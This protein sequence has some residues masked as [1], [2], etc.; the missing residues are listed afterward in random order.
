[1]RT[2]DPSS[3]LSICLWLLRYARRRWTGLVCVVALTLLLAG[4]KALNPWP[5]KFIVDQVLMSQPMPPWAGNALAWL[6]YAESPTQRLAWAVGATLALFLSGWALGL[7]SSIAHISFGQRMVY[8]LAADLFDHLQRLSLRYHGRK[9]VGDSIRRVTSDS[10]CVSTIIR[11]A[12]LPVGSSLI[13]LAVMVII[14]WKLDPGL[15]LAAVAVMPMLI[16]TLRLYAKPMMDRSYEQ[17]Q[18]EGQIYDRIEETFGAIPVVQAFAR[19]QYHD[20]QFRA[21][22]DAALAAA[23]RSTGVQLQFKILTGLATALGTAGI[24]W[25]GAA[26]VLDGR[27]SVGSILVFLAYLG[28]LYGPLEAIMYSSM[29]IQGAIGGARRV[30]EVFQTE[31]EVA[32]RPGARSMPVSRGHV[33]IEHVVFG[34]D[35]D[36]PVLRDV[37][38]EARPGQMIAIVGAS[39]AGK[40]TLVGLVPR[41]FDPWQGRV[42]LDGIDVRQIRLRDLRRQVALVLQEPFLFPTT[43]A[44]NIAYGRPRATPKQIEQAAC[45]AGAHEFI[46]KLKDGY[47]TVVGQRGATLSLGQRQ[48][49]AIAR[50][51]LRDAPVLI[52]D[53]PTSSLDAAT[54]Q[55]V[56]QAMT[57]LMRG[58]TTLLI[59][60]RLSTARHA[61]R[62]IVLEHGRIVQAGAHEQLLCAGGAY[63]RLYAA[64]ARGNDSPGSEYAG[65]G[66]VD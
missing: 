61:D 30:L 49:I 60:H 28:S 57:R 21:H 46:V 43:I 53:E 64:H 40:S 15:T 13:S 17:Q 52:L 23:M 1:M 48:R 2:S 14:M 3:I 12:M 39:G 37:S 8:D 55:Q 29:T 44:G 26:H 65:N 20:R 22:T 59:A 18:V 10:A 4:I 56:M 6:P 9:S 32:D 35:P 33:S 24:I 54:E 11:D 50:A 5:M 51:L 7:A 41:F 66:E 62:I 38:L 47:D 58:R 34:Y 36:R 31:Q 45:A 19:E 27:L 63:A 25:L 16:L 42:C